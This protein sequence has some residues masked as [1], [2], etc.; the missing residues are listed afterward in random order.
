MRSD[1]SS[2]DSMFT[3]HSPADSERPD[4][5]FTAHSPADSER[6]DSM[7][8]GRRLRTQAARHRTQT[9]PPRPDP[10]QGEAT[11]EIEPVD[12]ATIRDRTVV[13]GGEGRIT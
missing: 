2:V 1:P 7:F 9:G 8:T 6:P 12:R 5:M 11:P 13:G 4:S 10:P 3:A